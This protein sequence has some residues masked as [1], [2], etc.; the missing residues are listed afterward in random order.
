M[1]FLFASQFASAQYLAAFNDYLHRF[2]AFEAGT[3]TQLEYIEI[4]NYQVG[5]ILIAYLDNG[6]NLK[7][8]SHGETQTLM[9]G[10]PIKYKATDY[11]LGYSMYEQLNVF[12]NGKEKVL[13]TQADAYIIEDSLIVW[14]NRINKNI[15]V[16]YNGQVY[17]LEDGLIYQPIET[18]KTGDNLIAYVQSSTE[19]FKVFYLGETIVL[20]DFVQDF[21]FDAGRDIVAYIDVPDMEFKAFYR[22]EEYV[23]ENFKPNSFKAGDD[24]VAYV[25]NMGRLKL[26]VNGEVV[27]ISNFEPQFYEVTDRVLVYEEQ[28]FFKTYCNGEIYVVERY[29]PKPYRVDYNS[30]AY[31]DENR[32]VKVFQNCEPQ[33]INYA[34][35]KEF[36]LIRDLVIYVININ[37][38]AVYFNGETYEH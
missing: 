18:F 22:G 35:V 29:I 23:L 14:R 9:T 31:L 32:F 38:T 5:G 19:Q 28:G 25:D 13:S 6:S 17:Q 10:D 21:V 20:D 7:V 1:A 8:Y 3:F 30:I 4:Q 36:D 34:K 33:V 12:D 11:L 26:F 2:W 24:K 15:E 16:Y 37:K 27:D